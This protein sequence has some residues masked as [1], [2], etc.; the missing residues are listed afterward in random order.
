MVT[1]TW[2]PPDI[3]EHL[4]QKLLV[5][6]LNTVLDNEEGFDQLSFQQ[7]LARVRELTPKIKKMVA[8]LEAFTEQE[9]ERHRQV[10]EAENPPKE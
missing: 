2:T 6:V 5:A 1:L 3:S 9:I 7:Q 10:R 8:E 4:H